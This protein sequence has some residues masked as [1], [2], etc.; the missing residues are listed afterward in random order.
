AGVLLPD[1]T[2][3]FHWQTSALQPLLDIPLDTLLI[4]QQNIIWLGGAEG[5]FRFAIN[6]H[7]NLAAKQ[8]LLRRVRALNGTVFYHGGDVPTQLDLPSEHNQLRFEYAS[9]NYSHLQIA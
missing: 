1:D 6:E 4:D 9:P 8:P 2:G 7:R 3:A 5:V